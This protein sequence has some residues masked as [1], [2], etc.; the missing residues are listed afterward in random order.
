ME[1]RQAPHVHRPVKRNAPTFDARKVR[2]AAAD[3]GTLTV[4]A[5][6]RTFKGLRVRIGRPLFKPDEFAAALETHEGEAALLVN[7]PALDPKSRKV[8]DEHHVRNNL[9][10][11]IRRIRN[12]FSQFG[13]AFWE[14]ETDKG[15]RE[16]VIRGTTEHVRWLSDDRLL[17]TDV[18]GNRFEIPSILGLDRRSQSLL[19]LLL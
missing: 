1:A 15:F 12:L 7:L 18:H 19:S 14:V 4:K 8:L 6:G 3:D 10:T 16:F 13:A 11:P 2:L 5:N 9:T 17:I